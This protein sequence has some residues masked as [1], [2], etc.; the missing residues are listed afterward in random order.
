MT[1]V[2]RAYRYALDPTPTQE[3][4]FA[5]TNCGLVIDRDENAAVN[6][7]KLGLVVI[8]ESDSG[9]G[10]GGKCKSKGSSEPNAIAVE[11]SILKQ[12]LRVA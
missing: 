11:P 2:T 7:A 3:R 1:L 8:A 6:L 5:C 9:T 10:R 12:S 4:E